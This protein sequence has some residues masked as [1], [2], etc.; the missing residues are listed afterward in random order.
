MKRIW[1]QTCVWLCCLSLL[2]LVGCSAGSGLVP[3]VTNGFTC[4]AAIDYRELSVEGTMTCLD[5]GKLMLSFTRPDTLSGV[6]ISWD[7]ERM[8][9]EL[10]GVTVHLEESAIPQSAL[11]KNI[12]EV[13]N[14][15]HG[16]GV[17]SETGST[18]TGQIGD[19]AYTLVCDA[20]TGLPQSLSIPENELRAVFNNAERLPTTPTTA[21]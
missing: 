5:N 7:G 10:G 14:A 18:H 3:P 17:L 9:M 16:D 21:Q 15:S 8:A 11:I 6:T 4:T 2:I 1:V 12:L 19:M 13:L 20:T